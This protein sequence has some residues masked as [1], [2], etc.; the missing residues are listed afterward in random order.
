M[1]EQTIND[2]HIVLD[3]IDSRIEKSANNNEELQY[4]TYQKIKI[5]QLIDDFN[6][7]KEFF[8]NY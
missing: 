2:L 7:R 6:Q 1:S 5:L 8:V 3:N 4:L